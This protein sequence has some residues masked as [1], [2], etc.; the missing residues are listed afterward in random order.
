LQNEL[1]EVEEGS[2]LDQEPPVHVKLTELQL[3]IEA[4]RPLGA[5]VGEADCN[6]GLAAI[7][8]LEDVP[9]GGHDLERAAFH[10]V[11]ECSSEKLGRKHLCTGRT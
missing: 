7:P 9:A 8:D 10:N 11:G 4:Q 6:P 2:V 3:R 5:G 1:K